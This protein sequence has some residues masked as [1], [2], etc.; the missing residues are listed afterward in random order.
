MSAGNPQLDQS[1]R[2]TMTMTM[3]SEAVTVANV[4]NRLRTEP[5]RK[6]LED[7]ENRL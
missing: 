1:E 5:V 4:A 2:V 7:Q 6:R 3:T